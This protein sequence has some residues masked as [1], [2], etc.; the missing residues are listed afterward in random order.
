M[1]KAFFALGFMAIIVLVIIV[2]YRLK[3]KKVYNYR[4]FDNNHIHRN[5]TKYDE[6][7]F[8]YFGYDKHGYNQQ[9][10]NKFGKNEK[11][12]YNRYFDTTSSD[13]E[14]FLSTHTHPVSLSTHARER[15]QERI[16]IY[17][18]C[19]MDKCAEDAYR[20]GKSKR[21]IKKT[22]AYLVEEIEQ[23]YDNSVVLIY[24]NY[25]YVFSSDNVLK[26]VYRNNRIPL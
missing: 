11:G 5:G 4:G 16:G 13:E 8:D 25:V 21:Q 3:K 26:T 20:F 14:G 7:G 24:K 23:R 2:L 9:G 15:M 10:Y 6:Y 17:N 19:D 1:E 12:Q 22:S 18:S